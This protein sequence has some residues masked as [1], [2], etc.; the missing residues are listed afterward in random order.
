MQ[1]QEMT[2]T[3]RYSIP[4]NWKNVLNKKVDEAI[5]RRKNRGRPISIKDDLFIEELMNIPLPLKFKEPIDD[6]DG[7]NDPIDHIQTFQ[8]QVRLHGWPDAISYRE[9][10][11]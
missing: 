10:S 7:T 2:S 1:T 8:D 3:S 6:F 4:A 9:P 11:P 5:A